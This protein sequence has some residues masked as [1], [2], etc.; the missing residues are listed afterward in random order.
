[1]L[2]R[3]PFLVLLATSAALAQTTDATLSG[4][5]TDPSG[6]AIP[7]AEVNALNTRTGVRFDTTANDSGV[8]LFAALP[9]GGYRVTASHSGFRNVVFRDVVLEVGGRRTLD[10]QLEISTAAETVEVSADAESSLGYATSSVGGVVTARKV[11]DLP[12]TTR[13]AL[14][15]V[16]IQAGVVGDNFAGARMGTLN[17][18]I[19]GINVQDARI[20]TGVASTIFPS[21][22]RIEEFRVI[23]SPADA[24]LGRGSGQIQMVTRSGGNQFHGSLFNFHRNTPLNANTWFNNQR[25]LDPRTGEL[26]S[27]RN[28]LIR[29][30]FGGRVGGPILKNRTFFH[31][32]Y[33]GQ[34]IRTRNAVTSTV[35]TEP[36]RR[37]LFRF[38]PGIQNG[39]AESSSPVVDLQGNPARPAGA[40]GDLATASVFNR[41]PV[42]MA[43]DPTGIAVRAL[44]QLPLPNNFR[45]GDGL[46]TAGY[47]WTRRGSGDRD[48]LNLK[49]DHN[50]SV[51]HRLGFSW[52]RDAENGVNSFMAQTFPNSPGGSTTQRDNIYSLTMTSTLR[53]NLV[54]EIR[55]GALRP[56]HRFFAPWEV[57]GMGVLPK[58]ANESYLLT[59][60]TTTNP[61]NTD[62]DPQGRISP[63]Y[64]LFQKTSYLMGKH[65]IKFG[66][67]AWFV[68]TNGFNSFTVMPRVN[69]G[70]GG[71]P[72]RNIDLIPGIGRN[73]TAAQN[74]LL[75]LTG[76]VSSMQQAFNSP[77]GRNPAF[78][79]GEPKQRTWRQREFSLF[80]QDDYKITADLTLNLGL[81]YEW[82]GVPWEA[83]GKTAGLVGGS[84]GVFGLSGSSFSDLYQPGRL[85]GSLTL[86][87]QVGKNSPNAGR[88]LYNNDFN[89]FAPAIGVAWNLP[90]F[91][92]GKTVFRAGYSVGYERNSLRILDVV[93]GDQPGLRVVETLNSSSPLNLT[94][95]RLPLT[96]TVRPLE[97]VPLTD[98]TQIVRSFDSGLRSPY[99]QNWNATIDRSLPGRTTLSVRYV[100]NKGTRLVRGTSVNEHMIFENGLLNA[101]LLTQAGGNAPLFD[102]LLRGLN[103]PGMGVVDGVRVTGSQVFRQANTTTQGHLA[104]NNVGAFSAYVNNNPYLTNVRGGLLRNG[105]FPENWIVANPQFDSSRLT[106]NF[107]GSTYHSMQ[108]EVIKRFTAGW[109][110]QGNYTWSKALGEEEGAGQEMVDSYRDLR[111]WRLDKRLLAFH[112]T[113]VIRTN[114]IWDL[115]FGPNK[116][117]VAVK[118]GLLS[119]LVGG[120]QIGSI[121][122][123]F[124]GDP[125]VVS[126]GASSW[127]NFGD[128]TAMAAAVIDKGLGEVLRVGNGVT[129]F[130]GLRQ[131][132]DPVVPTL[133]TSGGVRGRSTLRA[134]TDESGRLLFFNPLPGTLGNTA[135]RLLQ[136]PGEFR[137]D[138]NVIKTVRISEG[139]N[140]QLEAIFENATNSPQFNN[141]NTDINSLNFGRI[142]GSGGT[143]IIVVAARF[144]F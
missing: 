99:V 49:I 113:H 46:N 137:L 139:K 95:V 17:I 138:L 111:N 34:R 27:P 9:P 135:P 45:F 44:D 87:E 77:G 10:I 56:R 134:I 128:N 68:S 4:S 30:Q 73:Q 35:L 26:I 106:G 122:N 23:T 96:T 108:V 124:S 14:G 85:A 92:K 89:N 120:W 2:F 52:S 69:L 54:N 93:A 84:A 16:Y 79:A 94:S 63:N 117:F 60:L 86:L 39:N 100:A 109:T 125:M 80:F 83:N 61:V 136:G 29:N 50:L 101:F 51:K 6:A 7:G 12:L 102:Q 28:I 141:P 57:V 133:T 142:T 97:L 76:S 32:L 21:T 59:T 72:V 90:F 64:Q 66:G 3:I 58:A 20:N 88:N 36:A 55:V 132:T 115:P 131:V 144:N 81:R 143:R 62:N 140:L 13:D 43:V 11:L 67:Q 110:F 41:D 116:R 53:S 82:Y 37:G 130:Q 104:G 71:A 1:M 19:D 42:R 127:N 75:D 107:A 112:R 24:E 8:Y 114:A 119:R 70:A 74:L 31:F 118:N 126:S 5:V 91:G 103:V 78:L 123:I 65:S 22:D 38:F 121:F 25:G 40:T 48:Q 18:Q 33:E 105:G 47:T 15:L 98:R 129:Y